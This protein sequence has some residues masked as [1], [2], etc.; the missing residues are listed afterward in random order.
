M[1]KK[2]NNITS[3]KGLKIKGNKKEQGKGEV[4]RPPYL[5]GNKKFV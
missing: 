2:K 3:N 4:T 1:K 5:K